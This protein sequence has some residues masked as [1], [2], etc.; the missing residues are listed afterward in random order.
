M[1]SLIE[2][3][4]SSTTIGKYYSAVF[5]FLNCFPDSIAPEDLWNKV[6]KEG[7]CKRHAHTLHEKSRAGTTNHRDA[8]ISKLKR[9]FVGGGQMR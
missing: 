3:K 7:Y 6:L 8:K 5:A 1:L 4:I 2:K 9:P